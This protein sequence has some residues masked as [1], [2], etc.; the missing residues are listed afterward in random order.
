[1]DEPLFLMIVDSHQLFRE[2]LAEVLSDG[3]G[4][5]RVEIASCEPVEPALLRLGDQRFDVLLVGL[6]LPGAPG[7]AGL[8]RQAV[9]RSPGL[10]AVVLGSAGADA[11]AVACLEAGARG[12]VQREQSLGELRAVIERVARGEVVLPPELAFR[13]FG[14]LGELGKE[15][16]RRRRLEFLDLTARAIEILGL[17][18]QGMSNQQIADRLHLSVHTVK[19]HV[20][21]ILERL[22][23]KTRA[24]AVRYARERGWLSRGPRG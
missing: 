12:Y 19:N 10:R 17:I 18:G 24:E 14:R 6:D 7:A 9:E 4:A 5:F 8:I 11:D 23:L 3:A 13:L 15:S 16:R 21:N 20:H 1:M 2:C 22:E